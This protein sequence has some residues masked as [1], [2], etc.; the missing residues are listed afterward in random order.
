MVPRVTFTHALQRHVAL[1]PVDVAGDTVREVLDAVFA[2]NERARGY[3]LDDRGLMRQ[4]MVVFVNG[5]LI[6]DREGLTDP[7]P[8]DGE[9]CVMQALSGG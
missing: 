7:V 2:D 8:P 3:I 5:A 6:K 1:P 9:V 4:H